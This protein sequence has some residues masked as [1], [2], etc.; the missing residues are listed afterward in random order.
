MSQYS[1]YLSAYGPPATPQQRPRF[2]EVMQNV[3]VLTKIGALCLVTGKLFMIV[4]VA[5]VFVPGLQAWAVPCLVV[6]G[7]LVTTTIILC[8]VD[9][10]LVN[11]KGAGTGGPVFASAADVLAYQYQPMPA[12]GDVLKPEE[13]RLTA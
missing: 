10:Y 3:G 1:H 8:T 5:A 12:G 9:H 13:E 7:S 11:P 2:A 4:S 6:W